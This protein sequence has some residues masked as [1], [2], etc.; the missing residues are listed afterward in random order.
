MT[1]NHKSHACRLEKLRYVFIELPKFAEQ[2]QKPNG[3]LTLEERCDR[4]LNQAH[5]SSTADRQTLIDGDLDFE[6]AF[7]ELERASWRQQERNT[8]DDTAIITMQKS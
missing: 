3:S 7:K 5:L 1:L 8:Y 2:C 4:F 6:K